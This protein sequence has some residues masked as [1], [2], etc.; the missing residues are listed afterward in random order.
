MTWTWHLSANALIIGLA[1]V[2]AS[3]TKARAPGGRSDSGVEERASA[4][5]AR[6]TG[7]GRSSP[8]S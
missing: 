3:G 6:G 4:C 5:A 2:G 7:P 8:S 1:I